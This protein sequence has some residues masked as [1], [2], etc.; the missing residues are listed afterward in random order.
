MTTILIVED[1]QGI[2]ET[3]AALF[4]ME[5]FEVLTAESATD[6]LKIIGAKLIDVM[7]SDI[8]LGSESGLELAYMVQENRPE[9]AVVLMTGY[10]SQNKEIRWPLLMKPFLCEEAVEIINRALALRGS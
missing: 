5:G 7:L 6:A 2:R 8:R 9:I 4:E 3:Q 10:S 1:E